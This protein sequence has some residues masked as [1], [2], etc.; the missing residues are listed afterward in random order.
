MTGTERDLGLM[1]LG[2]NQCEWDTMRLV[3]NRTE[4][5][6]DSVGLVNQSM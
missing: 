6:C 3:L 1:G 2:L 5:S 4:T